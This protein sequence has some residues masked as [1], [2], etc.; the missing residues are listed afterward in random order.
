MSYHRRMTRPD[1]T[2]T[3]IVAGL[4]KAG[5]AVWVIGIPCDLLCFYRGR[6]QTLECKPEK[7]RNRYDQE[8]QD[9]FLSATGT[10]IVRTALQA[11]AILTLRGEDHARA[12]E[13]AH[14]SAA[15]RGD[16]LDGNRH[17]LADRS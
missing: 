9:E 3:E 7:P 13:R 6:W 11:L 2:Q 12:K 15:P 17:L 14:P 5:V 4:R 8:A 1:A 16:D 10:P